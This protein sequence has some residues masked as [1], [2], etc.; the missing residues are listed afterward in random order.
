M[1]LDIDEPVTPDEIME[2][3]R[4]GARYQSRLPNDEIMR[5]A[6]AFYYQKRR[7]IETGGNIGKLITFDVLSGDYEFEDAR[8]CFV[9]A[10]RLRRRRPTA[11]RGTL[12]VG[13]KAAFKIGG[14]MT[15][16][17]PANLPAEAE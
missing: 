10:T 9:A 15:R 2:R 14:S 1:K 16:L 11:I 12:R 6:W 4:A 3:M 5:R 13:F 17:P 7:E 8:E